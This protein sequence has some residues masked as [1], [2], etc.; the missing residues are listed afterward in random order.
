[1][2]GHRQTKALLNLAPDMTDD[3]IAAS[4]AEAA[5]IFM[6]AYRV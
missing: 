2:L 1:V 3:E 4:A 5:R 6:R